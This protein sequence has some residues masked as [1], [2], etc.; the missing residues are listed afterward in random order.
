M[1]GE[2]TRPRV[3]RSAPRRTEGRKVRDGEDTITST[4][5]GRAPR[6]LFEQLPQ[7]LKHFLF[8]IGARAISEKEILAEVQCLSL[9]CRGIE[10]V[11]D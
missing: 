4:R 6:N 3:P 2:R 10:S 8:F 5:D 11:L 7:I 9:Y 1:I